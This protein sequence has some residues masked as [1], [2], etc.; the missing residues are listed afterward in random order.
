MAARSSSDRAGNFG[1]RRVLDD[2]FAG[3]RPSVQESLP[4][5]RAMKP[6]LTERAAYTFVYP[7]RPSGE[8]R[9][10]RKGRRIEETWRR[11]QPIL[12]EK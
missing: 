6:Q 8:W 3:V 1:V 5:A 10:P 2:L 9:S 7:F 4:L 12:T 11:G